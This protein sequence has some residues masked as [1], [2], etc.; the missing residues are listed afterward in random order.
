MAPALRPG[1]VVYCRR[2]GLPLG[3]GDY[4]VFGHPRRADMKL[5]KRVIGLPGETIVIDTGVVLVDGREGPD[6][7]SVGLTSPD[8]EWPVSTEEVFV[9][10][11][12]RSATMDDSR[13]FGPVPT[14]NLR[15]VWWVVRSRG[16][17]G[18]PPPLP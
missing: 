7:W 4:V 12:N 13:N 5:I 11:D 2:P 16:D 17:S 8:G 15:R 9:L 18:S 3:R 6:R 10:S 1:N 14:A